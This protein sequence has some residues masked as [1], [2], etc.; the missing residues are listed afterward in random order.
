[1]ARWKVDVGSTKLG[2]D[3]ETN[4][5]AVLTFGIG[6]MFHL[7][8]LRRDAENSIGDAFNLTIQGGLRL[9]KLT[10]EILQW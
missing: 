9:D 7:I 6:N 10:N 5:C 2:V 8:A 3:L 1:V 4:I